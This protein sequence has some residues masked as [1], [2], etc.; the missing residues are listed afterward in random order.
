M[1]THVPSP[2]CTSVRTCV[3]IC[4][5]RGGTH[6]WSTIPR[7]QTYNRT[8]RSVP[9]QGRIIAQDRTRRKRRRGSH[10]PVWVVGNVATALRRRSAL[11]P[12]GQPQRETR[13]GSPENYQGNAV[14]DPNA[15]MGMSCSHIQAAAECSLRRQA[16]ANAR[17]DGGKNLAEAYDSPRGR[18]TS[19]FCAMQL[20]LEQRLEHIVPRADAETACER[21]GGQVE[22]PPAHC[23]PGERRGWV[24]VAVGPPPGSVTRSAGPF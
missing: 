8:S 19:A 9:G 22:Q 23:Q 4:T 13:T 18:V 24:V 6:L 3:S 17:A 11:E 12:R 10:R 5:H 20:I 14:A 7:D 16:I 15:G 2:I 1:A 21:D